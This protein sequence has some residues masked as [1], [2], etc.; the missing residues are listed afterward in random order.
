MAKFDLAHL[1]ATYAVAERFVDHALRRDDSL[2][3]P[4]PPIWSLSNFEEL[5]R[6]YVQAP[7]PGEGTFEQKLKHQVG[8]G[9]SDAIQL[10]AELLFI[11]Y[12][13]ASGG[14]VT[15]DTK[16]DRISEVL[17]WAPS[18]VA[19]PE[20]LGDALDHG[21]GGGGVGFHTYKWASMSYLVRFG[22]MWKRLLEGDRNS[23]LADPW[24]FMSRADSV[25][26]EGGGTYAREALLHL[27]H[28]STFERIFSRG[29]KWNLANGFA[30]LTPDGAVDTDRRIAEIRTRLARRFGADFDF[31]STTPVM[32]MWK[33]AV[34]RWASFLYWARRFRDEP[35]F[36]AEE[37]DYKLALVD[38]L[39]LARQ[40]L[41]AG[42]ES[43]LD[44][45]G[46]ALKSRH[47]NLTDWRQHDTF[48]KWAAT[49]R[50]AAR[51]A[52][53]AIWEDGADP[54][55]ALRRFLDRMPKA[56]IATP[57]NRVSIGSVLLMAVNPY[58]HPP[59]RTVP[60]QLAF[61]LTD[62]GA[63]ETE[64]VA[65]YRQTLAFFDDVV[66]RGVVEGLELRDRLDA[67]SVT[68]CVAT[69]AP[70][71][72]WP[73]EDRAALIH[74]R[75]SAGKPAE[76]DEEEDEV[77]TAVPAG[78]VGLVATGI[79]LA[80][81]ADELLIDEEDLVEIA[82]LLEA[83]RQLV[84]YGPPGTGKTF[85]AKRLA[86]TLAG[87]A[88]RV[89]L[90]Q[91][92]PSYAYE[93]FVEGY[94][95]RLTDGQPGFE[96]VPGPLRRVAAQAA[97]DP[98]H[99]HF[100]IIDEMNRGNIAKVL[101]ELYFLLEYR[102]ELVE[103]QYSPE[104]F[105]MPGNLRIIGTMNTADRSI[106]LLDAA[107][108]RRFA[109]IPFFP[110]RPPIAGLLR[111]WLQRNQPEMSWVADVVDAANEQL[112][113]RNG[114]IGPS[115]FLVSGLDEARLGLIWKHEIM[116]YLEDHFFDDPRRLDAFELA[117]LTS[118]NVR[119]TMSSEPVEESREPDAAP[120]D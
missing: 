42:E 102:N 97:A 59:Y 117:R 7:D 53:A 20:D 108:R 46:K 76:G 100:L 26:T 83:K 22:E 15:G 37:R 36:D 62:F 55:D 9:S 116:P 13:P 84:F 18:Q 38:L 96:L 77:A 51:E 57:G 86:E 28:P 39:A 98:A 64:E 11:Y 48:L 35:N 94:R 31:Y 71:K 93:D 90:V 115:F 68:W 56:A 34:N 73:E 5:D 105:A 17:S 32:A 23:A 81:L 60:I 101:G 6:L 52:L 45:L 10:M 50:G 88:S 67:Q 89:R 43:W 118:D 82:H 95:P 106:A 66:Q 54:I 29:E 85:V 2:F 110:D 119:S 78:P 79:A 91:F 1:A 3:T 63:A 8:A 33:P 104:R 58:R 92:H 25:P 75:E 12:L 27:V 30:T 44:L 107:L 87:E 103:L 120:A 47:N 114:A 40:A 70:P 24:A 72:E 65:R 16:R 19:L 99:L 112:A 109:F 113:D 14:S 69:W 21:I 4:G 41:L 61:K 74:Y 80:P 111:R 49:E